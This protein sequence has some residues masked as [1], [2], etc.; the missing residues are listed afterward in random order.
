MWEF[1]QYFLNLSTK[2]KEEV[3]RNGKRCLCFVLQWSWSML[4]SWPRPVHFYIATESFHFGRLAARLTELI[5]QRQPQT[6]AVSGYS[7]VF[8]CSKHHFHSFKGSRRNTSLLWLIFHGARRCRSHTPWTTLRPPT[9]W[10][11]DGPHSP[12]EEEVLLLD[13]TG[14]WCGWVSR[15]AG[16]KHTPPPSAEDLYHTWRSR[17]PTL[18]SPTW[19]KQQVITDSL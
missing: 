10:G 4:T 7:P 18:L 12:A 3:E 2:W 15:S 5:S 19:G 13:S 16:G 6:A 17:L 1:Q 8:V 9:R 14:L 11:R